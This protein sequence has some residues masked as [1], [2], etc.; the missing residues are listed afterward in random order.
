MNAKEKKIALEKQQLSK[1]VNIVSAKALKNLKQLKADKGLKKAGKKAK[2]HKKG[3][4]ALA[5][6]TSVVIAMASTALFF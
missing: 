6:T 5:L 1:K 4:G 3:S 2:H